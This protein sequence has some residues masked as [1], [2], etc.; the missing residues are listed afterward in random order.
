MEI[1]ETIRLISQDG[2]TLAADLLP[3]EA[4][5][6]E[7]LLVDPRR[8]HTVRVVSGTDVILRDILA[9]DLAAREQNPLSP[10]GTPKG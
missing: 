1:I 5:A 2:R 4:S 8:V 7:R 9:A 10:S 6:I 3:Q